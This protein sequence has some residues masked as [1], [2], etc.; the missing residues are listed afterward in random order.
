[1]DSFHSL[2]ICCSSD[3]QAAGASRDWRVEGAELIGSGGFIVD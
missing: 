2:Q 1:L 3:A